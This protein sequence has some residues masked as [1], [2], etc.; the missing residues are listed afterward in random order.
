MVLTTDFPVGT[1]DWEQLV[2]VP[3]LQ[4]SVMLSMYHQNNS[5]P[6]E[7]IIGYNFDTNAWDVLDMGG[8]FRT[9][10]MPEGGESQGYFD[11]NPNDNAIEYHCCTSGSNQAENVNH[12]WWF[13]VLGQ[14]GRDKQGPLEPP[15]IALQ[16][17]GSFDAAH[18]VFVMY[19]GASFVGTWL[20][21]PVSNSWQSVKAGGTPPDPSV[22]LGG[23]AYSTKAQQVFLFG[24]RNG[25]GSY[26]QDL[27]YYDVP[28]NTWTMVNPVGGFKPPA[29]CCTNFAYDSTNNIFL[30]YGGKNANGVLGDTW[31][32]DPVANTWTQ[33]TPPQSPPVNTVSDFTRLTYDSDHNVFVLAHIGKG[34][35]MGGNFGTFAFQTWL[36]RYAGTGP[37]A[38]TLLNT[39]Q[40]APGS[41]ARNTLGWGKDPALAASGSSLFVGWTE[42]GSPFDTSNGAWAHIYADQYLGGT[43]SPLGTYS[44]ISLATTEAHLPSMA[45]VAGTPW[46]TWHQ[47]NVRVNQVYAASWNGSAWVSNLPIGLVGT[48]AVQGR[49]QIADIGSVPTVAFVEVNKAVSPQTAYAYV[50][51]WNGTAWNLVGTGAL[52]R[53]LTNGT[54]AT[55]IS[56]AS[57]GT[58]PYAAW[59]EYL[60]TSNSQG[61]L[62][63]SNPQAYVSH[64]DGT[65]WNPVG[66][67]VNVNP[68]SG[69]ANDASIAYYNGQPYVA[70]TERTQTGNNQ[71]YVKTWN[72]TSW[73][74]TGT[75]SLNQGG[76]SGWA[77]HPSLVADPVNNNL[78]VA[79]VEQ[80]ALG[81]KAQVFAAQ[82]VNGTWSSLGGS[83]NADPIN[84]SAQRVSLGVWNG[85]PV[86]SWAEVNLGS[87][88]TIY[89]AQWNGT[90]WTKL[91]GG[92]GPRDTTPPTVPTSL[93]GYAVSG[94]QVNLAWVNS[95]D[96]VGVRGYNIYRNGVK[97]GVA[98]EML[99]Y[100]DTGLTPNTAYTYRVSAY[101]AAGNNSIQS[102]AVIVTTPSQ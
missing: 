61:G 44:S 64:F 3:P 34:G 74:L 41:L 80:T 47:K 56:I 14:S 87:A 24:G 77:Y 66:G 68:A 15:P 50:K 21:N 73:V 27:F 28:S 32:Y 10:N 93:T 9:E 98:T 16:P 63:S 30:L 48:T 37:N 35:W 86:A 71:L 78:Y 11:F 22:I 101:D 18:D 55:S 79:W 23:S 52:N 12:T 49:S 65:Q 6:N 17:T 43:W 29:R 90:A 60:R 19:G 85:E 36:F 25:N 95:T 84:G 59:T 62:V 31:A 97:V 7:S 81:Q 38:G 13:D 26:S 2:Y 54:T 51:N 94:T 69:W 53:N 75:G 4:R 20:Y 92:G 1:N 8:V 67:S 72:G 46:I 88:R 102:T 99:K 40:P 83:L 5:E 89:A 76:A 33:L 45:I 58:N 96:K 91:S 39:T 42:L 57:D 82:Y 70:F 100:Q